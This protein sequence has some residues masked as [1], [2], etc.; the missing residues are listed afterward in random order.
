[1]Q[2]LLFKSARYTLGLGL[3]LLSL[4]ACQQDLTCY[5]P[6]GPDT[7][8][9]LGVTNF[10]GVDLQI[11]GDVRI[12]RDTAWAVS[13]SGPE[14]LIDRLQT[15]VDNGIWKI[16]YDG[17]IWG[18]EKLSIDISMPE[19]DYARIAGSGDIV[20]LD[21]FVTTSVSFI[22]S[23]SGNLTALMAADEV[24]TRIN[25]SGDIT[26]WT[27]AQT[28]STE[29]N[30]SGDLLLRGLADNH[31]VEVR[32]AGSIQAFDLQTLL[33]DISVSGSGQS[34]VWATQTLKVSISGSGDVHYIG[35]PAIDVR[36]NGSGKVLD[37]N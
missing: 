12:S 25:G 9:V 34:E 27:L 18:S 14:D 28:L 35:T 22:I 20:L 11:A 13:V 24:S 15:S 2:N 29:V 23:G 19:L 3:F 6:I 32:G 33:T 5:R 30:G 1:M 21:T 31:V 17:C 7:T 4:S 16:D 37:V 26:L 10:T 36:I 8:R